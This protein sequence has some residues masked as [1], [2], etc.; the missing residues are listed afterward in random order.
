MSSG[1]G[2]TT[3]VTK[4]EL[5]AWLQD[6]AQGN[7]ARA[8]FVS[9][10]GYVPQYG[11]DVAGFTPMQ[12]SAMQNTADAAS[13]FGLQAPSNAMA[14]MP[15][16]QTNNLG[17]S[18]YSSG[19]LYR[20][21][22]G[23]FQQQAPSQFAALNSMFIDP[24]TGELGVSWDKSGTAVVNPDAQYTSYAPSSMGGNYVAPEGSSFPDNYVTQN[25]GLMPTW[26]EDVALSAA[27]MGPIGTFLSPVSKMLGTFAIDNQMDTLAQQ[28]SVYDHPD[29]GKE[30]F[31]VVADKYGNL[32]LVDRTAERVAREQAAAQAAANRAS[33]NY[34]TDT[35][36]SGNNY[37]VSNSN[38]GYSANFSSNPSFGSGTFD[39]SGTFGD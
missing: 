1:G 11:L 30:G 31:E 5:P 15:A 12:T 3:Q 25:T 8:D 23:N 35:Y 19:D 22:L 7:L 38:T 27:N 37:T 16:Q 39:T 32:N 24:V 2:T 17:F 10:I 28:Q 21:Y 33:G 14:G 20:D 9:K 6:A 36:G 13:A 34:Y 26:M 18:G 29:Y 4:N